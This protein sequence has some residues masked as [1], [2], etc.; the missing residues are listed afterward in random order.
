MEGGARRG[1]SDAMQEEFDSRLQT[2][3][4]AMSQG[5]QVPLEAG[6]GQTRSSQEPEEKDTAPWAP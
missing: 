2:L 5:M 3:K 1:Q 4:R 6:K